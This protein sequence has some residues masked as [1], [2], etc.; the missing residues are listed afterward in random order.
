MTNMERLYYSV[1]KFTEARAAARTEYLDKMNQLDGFRGS[2][3]YNDEQRKAADRRRE[4]V[5]AAKLD[6]VAG[7]NAALDAMRKTVA[8]RPARELTPG[9]IALLQA[10]KMRKV[11]GTH[12]LEE[13]A[14]AM[15]GIGTGLRVLQEISD[16]Q[17]AMQQR[18]E[19]NHAGKPDGNETRFRPVNCLAMITD[20]LN[21]DSERTPDSVIDSLAQSCR[22]ILETSVA[23][24]A[25]AAAKHN[26]L[27]TGVKI[28]PDQ[29]KQEP[30][31]ESEQD[32]YGRVVAV[33][34]VE[35]TRTL[36]ARETA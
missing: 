13:A 20:G 35:L 4:A 30:L 18:G 29:L 33:P 3:Y 8:T 16:E 32:F 36:N 7:V 27:R 10:L 25:Y 5:E 23:R 19:R 12:E 11:V 2:D 9:Q 28:D 22:R 1:K 26:E 21:G 34:Y 31:Y 17:W 15:D 14:H 24:P 6:Y